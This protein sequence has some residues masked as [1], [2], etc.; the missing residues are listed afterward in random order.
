MYVPSGTVSAKHLFHYCDSSEDGKDNIE[1]NNVLQCWSRLSFAL[2]LRKTS[3]TRDGSTCRHKR[4][5]PYEHAKDLPMPL[6]RELHDSRPRA[7]DSFCH[8]FALFPNVTLG[9]VISTVVSGRALT[10]LLPR[11]QS[12]DWL[13]MTGTCV[14]HDTILEILS[15]NNHSYSSIV[16]RP[17]AN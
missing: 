8:A 17:Y 9:F 16:L 3:S 13:Y 5:T 15:P 11:D 1:A 7:L 6:N 10:I 4:S 12:Q 2:K 14:L